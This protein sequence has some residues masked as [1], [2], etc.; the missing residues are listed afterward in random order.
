[1]ISIVKLENV[2]KK[3]GE[4][5]AVD[6]V[7]LHIR[8]DDIYGLIGKNGAGKTTVL[9]MIT[10][11]IEP[12][13]GILSLLGTEEGRMS[14]QEALSRTASVIETPVAYQ[15]MT[16]K[17]NLEYYRIARGIPDKHAVEDA[18]RLVHLENTGKKKFKN[19]SL[20]M[21]QR[22]G[23][24][25]AI[26]NNPDFIILDEPINGLDPIAIIEFRELLKN[27]NEQYGITIL[28]SS[29]IL[30]ELYHVATRF[31]IIN[32]GRLI[33]E[34]TKKDFDEQATEYLVLKTKNV[35]E[36]T[37]ILDEQIHCDYKVL[38]TEEI[39]IFDYQGDVADLNY[40]LTQQGVRIQSLNEVSI[41]LEN[42]FTQLIKENSNV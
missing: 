2:T 1:M 28:I 36:A 37:R 40:E 17:E 33:K 41:D 12:T 25:I 14:Y 38:S 13:S 18:L 34:F 16:A 11:L 6:N 22:L 8:K 15:N 29:H 7:S 20:G 24:A 10:S 39:H 21:K 42:Y 19:F 30:T 3:F 27:L 4:Q 26:L 5:V 23:I 32:E 35:T 31:G 9:K